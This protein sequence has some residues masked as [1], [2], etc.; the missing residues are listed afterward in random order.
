M[1][2]KVPGASFEDFRVSGFRASSDNGIFFWNKMRKTTTTSE[3][4]E[5]TNEIGV[6]ALGDKSI[7]SSTNTPPYP[8][9]P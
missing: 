4:V 5:R 2:P 7:E 9:F 1:S 3:R 6:F 8:G